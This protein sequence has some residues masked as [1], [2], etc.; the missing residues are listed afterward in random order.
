MK[1][2]SITLAIMCLCHNIGIV[3]PTTQSISFRSTSN[4][5]WV[6]DDS[7]SGAD[8]DGSFWKPTIDSDQGESFLTFTNMVSHSDPTGTYKAFV[9]T[10]APDGVLEEPDGATLIWSDKKS[11]GDNDIFCFRPY[12]HG[13][14]C[15]G[16]FI[17]KVS[18]I[19]SY[20]GYKCIRDD[21]VYDLGKSASVAQKWDD[22]GS[23]SAADGQVLSIAIDVPPNIYF[24]MTN[25]Y[26]TAYTRG[27]YGLI[28]QK[29]DSPTPKP[30]PNPTKKPT[31]KPTSNPTVKPTPNPT[32]NPTYTPT[33]K[34]TTN[35]SV[36]PSTT[37][38]YNPTSHPITDE[39]SA[40][41]SKYPTRAPST[42]RPTL[43]VKVRTHP[44]TYTPTPKPTT[45]PSV[46]PST[47]PTYN[48]TS[49]PITD[50]PSAHPSKY[51]TR[52]P[53]TGRPTL[54]VKVRTHPPTYPEQM[55]TDS[56]PVIVTVEAT[57]DKKEDSSTDSISSGISIDLDDLL[58]VVSALLVLCCICIFLC[59]WY[60][61]ERIW[62]ELLH[63]QERSVHLS[64]PLMNDVPRAGQDGI[65]IF[66]SYDSNNLFVF[67]GSHGSGM[68]NVIES[69]I[70][71]KDSNSWAPQK[72]HGASIAISLCDDRSSVG[73]ARDVE[74]LDVVLVVNATHGNAL[75]GN[76]VD[77]NRLSNDDEFVVT[78]DEGEISTPGVGLEMN[79]QDEVK[80]NT[81]AFI[82]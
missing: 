24:V 11:G 58:I 1:I 30:T 22:R 69:S 35:P 78:G 26:S 19:K 50:E 57:P 33:P 77:M 27:F 38:T 16:D 5:D 13:Y 2:Q 41:P 79:D 31:A 61:K 23:G 68:Q 76:G 65:R 34:P 17:S 3:M 55:V 10:S 71:S 80:Q 70:N 8:L 46:Y 54:Y 20:D 42:G 67:D 53:S 12:L 82:E 66:G 18:S 43:Y 45:N 48:P 29:T 21:W 56:A 81:Q 7:G 63:D 72:S 52:A 74:D 25:T 4:Y 47:T 9:L 37:P 44:P 75:K 36:Y 15:L 28:M 14:T 73:K 6:W 59:Y 51:P 32:Y 39:P 64:K 40:H 49:H 62:K 60:R